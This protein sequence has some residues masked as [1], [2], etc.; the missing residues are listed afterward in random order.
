MKETELPQGVEL[1]SEVDESEH[2]KN[3]SQKEDLGSVEYIKTV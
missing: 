3:I 1:S 2:L